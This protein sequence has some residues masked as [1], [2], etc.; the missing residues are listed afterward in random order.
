MKCRM[1]RGKELADVLSAHGDGNGRERL[2][3]EVQ[4]Y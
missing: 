2:E 3:R 1:K 4:I